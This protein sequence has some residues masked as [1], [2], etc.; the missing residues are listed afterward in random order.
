MLPLYSLMQEM[1]VA[2]LAG[3]VDR[4][5]GL[6]APVDQQQVSLPSRGAW[7]EISWSGGQTARRQ[8][9]PSRGAWIEICHPGRPAPRP[10][11]SLPSRGAWIEITVTDRTIKA[12]CVAPLAGS[13]DR[14][15]RAARE[16][17]ALG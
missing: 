2:P 1:T 6:D 17:D 9:L 4:N 8:S 12:I 15:L 13:V 3:S 16:L 10:P 14:N 5:V 7:I 11:R